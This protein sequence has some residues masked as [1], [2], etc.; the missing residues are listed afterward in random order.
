[1]CPI[2]CELVNAK[3]A[4]LLVIV[5]THISES[6]TSVFGIVTPFCVST[7]LV[8]GYKTAIKVLPA[9]PLIVTAPPYVNCVGA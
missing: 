9:Q 3:D 5:P 6:E 1:M 7:T 8:D 4:L 2:P